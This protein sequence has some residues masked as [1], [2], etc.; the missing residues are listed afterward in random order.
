[1]TKATISKEPKTKQAVRFFCITMAILLVA[2]IFI[3]G[4]QSD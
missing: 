1:M 3:W 4:F 2:S